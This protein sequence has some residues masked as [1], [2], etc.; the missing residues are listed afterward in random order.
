M[1]RGRICRYRKETPPRRMR[2]ADMPKDRREPGSGLASSLIGIN[3]LW[4]LEA[5]VRVMCTPEQTQC[6]IGPPFRI[7]PA[8]MPG[9]HPEF[10]YLCPSQLVRRSLRA[11][12]VSAV[13]GMGIGAGIVLSLTERRFA[14][15]PQ[16]RQ[17]STLAR[18]DRARSAV[19]QTA[20][21]ETEPAAASV[22]GVDKTGATASEACDDEAVSYL[23][24]R[25]R[26]VRRHKAHTSQSRAFWLATV[27]IDRSRS[28]GDVKRPVS[29]ALNGKSIQ[30]D[31]DR[32]STADGPTVPSTAVSD[33][34]PAS[35]PKPARNPRTRRRPRDP[36]GDGMK[37]F[38]YALAQYYRPGDTYRSGSHVVKDNWGWRW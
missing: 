34:V 33:Q 5:M 35:A 29:A 12:L 16:N 11:A 30:T 23:D 22:A 10:G 37:A 1:A 19:A 8:V 7:E 25:C 4:G 9:Y 32:I 36:K 24:S 18:T 13:L 2:E 17:A 28:I 6:V 38:A 31:A 27:E 3:T 14:A 15:S 26:S 21:P 20:A